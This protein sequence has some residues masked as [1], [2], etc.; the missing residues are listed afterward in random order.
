MRRPLAAGG[1]PSRV[2]STGRSLACPAHAACE[3]IKRFQAQSPGSEGKECLLFMEPVGGPTGSSGQGGFG[4]LGPG[5]TAPVTALKGLA[6]A[7]FHFLPFPLRLIPAGAE[8]ADF[9]R[10]IRRDITIDLS[11]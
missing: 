1:G 10:F 3:E 11:H 4:S 2:A 5:L 9:A 8:G 7:P 6:G